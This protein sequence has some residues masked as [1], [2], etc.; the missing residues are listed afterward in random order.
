MPR[1]TRCFS[2]TTPDRHHDAEGSKDNS[3]RGP[4][5]PSAQAFCLPTRGIPR[6]ESGGLPDTGRGTNVALW[7]KHHSGRVAALIKNEY[8]NLRP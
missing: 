8:L 7:L 3:G 5:I 2:A 6:A 1:S 4:V